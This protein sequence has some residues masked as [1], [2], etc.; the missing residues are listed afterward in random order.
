MYTPTNIGYQKKTNVV[1]NGNKNQLE[2]KTHHMKTELRHRT[3]TEIIVKLNM[4][5]K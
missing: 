3:E 2:L 4:L 5:H 1:V